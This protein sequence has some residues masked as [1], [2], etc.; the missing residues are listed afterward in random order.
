MIQLNVGFKKSFFGVPVVR[1]KPLWFEFRLA[2]LEYAVE[3]IMKIEL[4]QLGNVKSE[5]D[6]N[7]A[8]L[9]AGYYMASI[10]GKQKLKY[11]LHHAVYGLNI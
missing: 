11:S 3:E 8:I 4:H 2:S 7:L 9:Y 1:Y 5:Y 6:L 10:K